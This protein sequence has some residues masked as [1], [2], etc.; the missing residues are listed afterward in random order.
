MMRPFGPPFL[1]NAQH[2]FI[3]DKIKCFS[4]NLF[5]N[6]LLGFLISILINIYLF[7]CLFKD[8]HLLTI[9]FELILFSL[10]KDILIVNIFNTKKK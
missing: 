3:E 6:K 9:F 8:K 1:L 5:E 10:V 7:Y 4:S 2:S